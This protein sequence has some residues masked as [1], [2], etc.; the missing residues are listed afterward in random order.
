MTPEEFREWER[1]HPNRGKEYVHKPG[2][3]H[4]PATMPEKKVSKGVVGKIIGEVG[5][6]VRDFLKG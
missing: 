4:V 3:V 6:R 2:Y 5:D 1:T